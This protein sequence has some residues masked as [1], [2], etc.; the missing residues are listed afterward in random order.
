M[1]AQRASAKARVNLSAHVIQQIRRKH[2]PAAGVPLARSPLCCRRTDGDASLLQSYPVQI[3]FFVAEPRKQGILLEP[4]IYLF[5][6][7]AKSTE[8]EKP[9]VY[10]I[11]EENTVTNAS[12]S[13]CF[14]YERCS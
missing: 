4:Q 8:Q 11:D 7:N 1:Q 6:G 10:V 5:G 13:L 9:L 12:S 2:A 3:P 14:N